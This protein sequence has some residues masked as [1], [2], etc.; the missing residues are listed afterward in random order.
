MTFRV[1]A[2]RRGMFD[3]TGPRHGRFDGRDAAGWIGSDKCRRVTPPPPRETKG[4]QRKPDLEDELIVVVDE[5]GAPS[6]K[7][8]KPAAT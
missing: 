2:P 4:D 5:D 3:G 1:R 7:V 8:A 6:C